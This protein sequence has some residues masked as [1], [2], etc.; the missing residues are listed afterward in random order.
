[1][2]RWL[3][4]A[5]LQATNRHVEISAVHINFSSSSNYLYPLE[6]P[7][8]WMHKPSGMPTCLV[9]QPGALISSTQAARLQVHWPTSPAASWLSD[10]AQVHGHGQTT[11]ST[12]PS[13]HRRSRVS[14]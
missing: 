6:T 13:A 12:Q 9:L 7:G 1:M 3:N 5:Q 11:A 10:P 4:I 2:T 8:T 14:E